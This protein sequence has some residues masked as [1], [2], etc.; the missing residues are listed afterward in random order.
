[1]VDDG[2]DE[3]AGSLIREHDLRV[4]EDGVQV[5]VE[6][7]HF[8]F[9]EPGI[10]DAEDSQRWANFLELSRRGYV[11][12]LSGTVEAVTGNPDTGASRALDNPDTG[13]GHGRQSGHSRHTEEEAVPG[14][15]HSLEAFSRVR[16][17]KRVRIA[18]RAN[19]AIAFLAMQ[20]LS[21]FLPTTSAGLAARAGVS[22]RTAQRVLR[23]L[24]GSGLA[25]HAGTTKARRYYAAGRSA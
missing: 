18:R 10:T 5:R 13:S 3:L 21:P 17:A 19:P 15:T 22:Q 16:I 23:E 20:M 12:S 4:L 7:R 11:T 14:D 8:D 2:H 24:V 9:K 6:R 25:R 1:M